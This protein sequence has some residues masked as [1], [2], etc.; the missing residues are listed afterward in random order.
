[1]SRTLTTR[2]APLL[3][4]AAVL[5]LSLPAAAQSAATVNAQLSGAPEEHFPLNGQ[6]SLT[7]SMGS[8]TYVMSPPNPTLSSRLSLQPTARL[9]PGWLLGVN[10]SIGFEWTRSDSTTYANQLELSD[11]GVRVTYTGIAWD[12]LGLRLALSGGYSLPISMASRQIGSTGPMSV[13]SR[14]TW[15]GV[16]GFNAY[17]SARVGVNPIFS[18]LAERFHDQAGKKYVDRLGRSIATVACNPRNDEELAGFVCL[19]GGF[20]SVVTWS[21][22]GG[23]GYTPPVLNESLFIGLDFTFAQGFSAF[24]GPD[25][26][27]RATRAAAG[28]V[29]RESTQTNLSVSWTPEPWFIL[30][31]GL[32]SGQ[33]F[34]ASNSVTP[35]LP[36]VDGFLCISDGN[37][38]T[39]G[40]YCP[41][42]QNFSSIYIDTTFNF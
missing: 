39:A 16:A 36:L 10:Q 15:N 19:D 12:D 11:L 8:A 21:A 31:G 13:S 4:A 23:L 9:A 34:L 25:D 6:V 22:G 41:A 38:A 40:D 27:Y 1:M 42:A 35:R 24:V 30:T 29:P 37:A 14:L 32:F 20:P 33:P 18:G 17:G 26:E 5:A 7:H 28:L 3:L 2:S